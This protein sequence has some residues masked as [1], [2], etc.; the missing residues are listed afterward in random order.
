[1]LRGDLDVDVILVAVDVAILDAAVGEMDLVVEVRQV[2]VVRPLLGLARVTVRPSIGVR[3]APV[4]FV[5][6]PLVLALQL[7]VQPNTLD[8]Q[9]PRLEPRRLAFVGAVD[10]CVV[11]ELAFAF[12]S[13]VE[14]LA[15]ISVAVPIRFQQ[16]PAAV[17]QHDRLL[18]ITRDANRLD[19]PLFS[20][21]PEV[22]IA[23]IA[24]TV[25][26]VA[27][28]SRGHDTKGADGR[29]RTAL[30]SP[31]RVFAIARIMDHFA[32]TPARQVEATRKHVTRVA[33]AV[34]RVAIALWPSDVV[35][36]A[37]IGAV[38][39]IVPIVVAFTFVMG[40]GRRTRSTS[41]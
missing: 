41:K 24:G 35:P 10:L 32:V 5:K 7:V 29:Q 16:S 12:E 31:Q 17:C 38:T 15:G 3:P 34:P 39:R 22:A 6:P 20:Q 14:G 27:Q 8:L 2:M 11:F 33:R 36:I 40:L 26:T 18:A 23:H 28:L 4:T 13:G 25:V 1:M 37:M 21:M 9:A 30:G 19:Q